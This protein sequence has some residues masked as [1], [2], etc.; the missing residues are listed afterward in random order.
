MSSATGVPQSLRAAEQNGLEQ[1]ETEPLLGAPGDAAQI[2]GGSFLK[3]LVLGTGLIAET[4]V[5]LLFVLVWASVF[6]KPVILFSGHPLAQS[7]GVL[8]LVQSIL[9]LQ[10]T[11]TPDQKRVGQRFHA[12]LHLVAFLSLATGVII[13]EYN[14]VKN[15]MPHFHSVHGYLG[16][17]TSI[18]LLLQYFVGFTM[19]ATPS[20]Y[21]GVDNA[22]AIW[23]YHRLSGYTILVLLLATVCSAT[24]TTYNFGVLKIKLWATIL[25]SVLIL[26][27]IIP[28]IQKQKFGFKPAVAQ[29]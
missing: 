10:P 19:W 29:H 13:I 15:N 17:I 12:S 27:G 26:T 11:H 5:V 14:K 8:I 22:K 6:T 25:L 28:R 7:L 4:A 18:V 16:V 9:V 2:R 24:Q 23:K 20:L 21:G 1:V 3:N